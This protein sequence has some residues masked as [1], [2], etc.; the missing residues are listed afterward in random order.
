M[1][2]LG[3]YIENFRVSKLAQFKIRYLGKEDKLVKNF[4][5]SLNLN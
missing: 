4:I 1:F 5:L 2:K 3:F